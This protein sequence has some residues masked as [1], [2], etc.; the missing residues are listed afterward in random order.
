[1]QIRNPSHAGIV[2]GFV[3]FGLV[4]I[5]LRA[6]T[7]QDKPTYRITG[8]EATLDGTISFAGTAPEAKRIDMSADPMCETLNPDST[9]DW[10]VVVTNNKLA[11]VLV[12]VRGEHLNAYSFD[13]PSPYVTLDHRRCRYTPHVLGMQ[14]LQTLKIV[15]SDTTTHNTH[16][17]PKSNPDRN[18]SQPPS[19]AD[20]EY[21]FTLPELFIPMKCNQH[22]WERAVVAVFSHPFFSVTSTD[23]SYKIS[24]LPPGQYTVAAWHEEL[25]E[26]T[27]DLFLTGNEGRTL[28]FTFRA[29]KH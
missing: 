20:L 17:T 7:N 12:Y 1:M 2:V 10:G 8:S 18:Q 24:G 9:I 15:N 29:S 21:R 22:P 28:D 4:G 25:G 26:Q 16:A 11:D 5:S 27:V 19:A 13:A 3:L 23:G 6:S 14:T